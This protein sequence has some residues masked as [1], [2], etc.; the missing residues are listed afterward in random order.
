MREVSYAKSTYQYRLDPANPLVIERKPNRPYARWKR[1][2]LCESVTEA[3]IELVKLG[4]QDDTG[5]EV[6]P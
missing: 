3:K 1:Y 4:R 6:Q 2:R 5:V